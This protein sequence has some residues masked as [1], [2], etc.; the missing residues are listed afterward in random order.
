MYKKLFANS[1]Q[2]IIIP[3]FG[4]FLGME[5]FSSRLLQDILY[6]K[7]KYN[8]V[9]IPLPEIIT[10]IHNLQLRVRIEIRLGFEA[11]HPVGYHKITGMLLDCVPCGLVCVCV[12][13]CV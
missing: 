4:L 13:V 10:S 1:V 12:C 2:K 11:N 9:Y 3:C 5:L 6:S 8:V 7:P